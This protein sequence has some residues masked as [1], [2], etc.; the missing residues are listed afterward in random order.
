MAIETYT[1]PIGTG[2]TPEERVMLEEAQKL[3]QVFDDDCPKLNTEQL[4]QFRPVMHHVSRSVTT[5]TLHLDTDVF[6]WYIDQ[7]DD[8]EA[9]INSALRQA[10]A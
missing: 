3:P 6:R 7:G 8:Y 9:R 1:R 4:A 10:I 5:V 2:L